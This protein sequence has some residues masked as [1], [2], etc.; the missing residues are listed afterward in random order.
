MMGDLVLV[1]S[2]IVIVITVIY[3]VA[4]RRE[5]RDEDNIRAKAK[6]LESLERAVKNLS[7]E[8]K[9]V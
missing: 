8:M 9:D 7:E 3:F 1:I 2:L 4:S 5:E 6:D